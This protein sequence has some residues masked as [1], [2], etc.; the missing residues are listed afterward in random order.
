MVRTQVVDIELLDMQIVRCIWP[1][2]HWL[3]GS[4]YLWGR[5]QAA[6]ELCRLNRRQAKLLNFHDDL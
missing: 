6:K 5:L 3:A 1:K 2:F 4:S